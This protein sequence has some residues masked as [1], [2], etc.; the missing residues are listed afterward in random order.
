M[1][2]PEEFDGALVRIGRLNYTWTNTES[3]LI[4]LIAGLAGTT[5]RRHH[6]P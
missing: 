6:L 2:P 4:H 1:I 5:S 3:V